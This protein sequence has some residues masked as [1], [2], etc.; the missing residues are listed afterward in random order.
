[1]Q[2][3]YYK[4]LCGIESEGILIFFLIDTSHPRPREGQWNVCANFAVSNLFP[5]GHALDTPNPQELPPGLSKNISKNPLLFA[6]KLSQ[7]LS[8]LLAEKTP[9]LYTA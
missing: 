1:M 6:Q 3:L 4:N 2:H 8:R 5:G 9:F 7:K